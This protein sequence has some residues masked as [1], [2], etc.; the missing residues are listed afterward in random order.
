MKHRL[1][2][3]PLFVLLGQ[4]VYTSDILFIS[5]QNQKNGHG[6]DFIRNQNDSHP[7][8]RLK[9]YINFS[10]YNIIEI[11]S[12]LQYQVLNVATKVKLLQVQ[13]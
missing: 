13:S 7:T 1:F 5:S 4:Q 11:Y 8:V 12:L 6:L 9:K 2:L 3:L 10:N